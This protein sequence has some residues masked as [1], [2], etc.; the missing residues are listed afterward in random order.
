VVPAPR[1]VFVVLTRSDELL[2]Q[3]G[4]VLD[5]AGEVR[6]AEN[7]E[8]ARQF[9]D[10]RYAAVML[11]D[12]RE[13]TDPDLLVERLHSSDGTTVIVVFAP[14]DAVADVARAI[15]G[16]AAFAVLPIPVEMEKTRAVLHGA[17]EEAMARRALLASA[18][19]AVPV[20]AAPD[21][22]PPVRD[23]GSEHPLVVPSPVDAQH[24]VPAAP[25]PVAPAAA[26][27]A[28]RGAG[29]IPRVALAVA[30]GLLVA[31]VAAWFQLRDAGS[32]PE[33]VV[34]EVTAPSA[35]PG[36]PEAPQAA[37]VAPSRPARPLSTEPKE[38][39]LDQARVAFHERRYTDPDGDNALYYYRSV[40]AQDPQDDEA[41][42]GLDR[43]GSVLDGRLESA[44]AE[45][46]T[47]DAARTLEQLRSIRPDDASLVATEA[48]ITEGRIAA[49]LARGDLERAAALLRAADKTGVAPE[50][51]ATLR[52]QLARLD[53]AQRA[54]Q[55]SRLVGARIRDGRL[56]APPG[57]SA[58]HYL[59]QLLALPNG[60]RL[61]A[62]ASAELAR[63][64]A[65]RARR[66]AAQGQVAEADQWFAEARA[67]GYTPERPAVGPAA[68]AAAAPVVPDTSTMQ[69]PAESAAAV[70]RDPGVSEAT[71]SAMAEPGPRPETLA[72]SYT[73]I[74]PA[75]APVAP[76]VS[77]ADFRRTRFVAPIYPPQALARG[78]RGEV[79]VRITVDTEGRVA[80]A[81]V[82][83]ASPVEVFDEAAINA[84]RKWRFEPVVKNGRRIE[85]SIATT[86]RFQP[87]DAQR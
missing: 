53:A 44:L 71:R 2:E 47:E 32:P 27:G 62:D 1:T 63:A 60:K 75:V 51:L 72:A 66:A 46:R 35:A 45:Q 29:G 22:P 13:H 49:A 50:R 11:L 61:G 41:R 59:G 39:L 7:E 26:A 4:Q 57:D 10:P 73:P 77:A 25:G 18:V 6:H 81:Q 80:D 56:L 74:T 17:G 76:E 86:I 36:A 31:A 16:S 43:I 67:L 78:L 82:L 30:A 21:A 23:A 40:L 87:E 55:L 5:D 19:E 20:G 12:A 8:E 42:E 15:R 54:E 48:R 24:E 70:P 37:A 9:A 3:I 79:R 14:A 83:S 69:R 28:S 33:D 68:Q 85:A 34:A 52:E 64:F 58:K 84:V 65:E 38:Q